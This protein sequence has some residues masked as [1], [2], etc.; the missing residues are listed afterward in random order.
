[1]SSPECGGACSIADHAAERTWCHLDNMQFGTTLR[2]ATPRANC[3]ACGIRTIA[4]P[5]V[6]KYSRFTPLFEAFAIRALQA[7]SSIKR[8][9][10]LLRV[11]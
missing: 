2:A 3:R 11:D 5:R 9:A 1:V 4:V 10:E 8:T 7:A 6:G